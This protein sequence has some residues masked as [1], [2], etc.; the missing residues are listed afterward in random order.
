MNVTQPESES[1][2]EQSSRGKQLSTIY[3]NS[4]TD[5]KSTPIRVTMPLL[6]VPPLPP[7]PPKKKCLLSG[8]G[9]ASQRNFEQ[10]K[11]RNSSCDDLRAVVEA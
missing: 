7:R 1:V 2:T 11:K 9:T 4:S 5:R 8:L 10:S 3:I 6:I